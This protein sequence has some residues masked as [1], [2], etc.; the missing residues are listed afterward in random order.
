MIINGKLIILFEHQST[1]N[2]NMPLRCLEYYVHLLYGIIPAEARYKE[3][4]IRFQLQNFMF[5]TM[6]QKS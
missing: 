2:N 6:E 3:A 1:P 5:F 4:L